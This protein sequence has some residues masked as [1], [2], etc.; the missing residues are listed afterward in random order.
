MGSTVLHAGEAANV[1]DSSRRRE[2]ADLDVF[3]GRGLF[4]LNRRLFCRFTSTSS[5]HGGSSFWFG[6][7]RQHFGPIRAPPKLTY[8]TER[9]G[10]GAEL[11]RLE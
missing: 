3:A 4:V 1:V 11:R 10:V 8:V 5:I 9:C 7:S 6:A 2:P